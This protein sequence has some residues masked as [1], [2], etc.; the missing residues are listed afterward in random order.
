MR[1]SRCEIDKNEEE[2]YFRNSK[3]R[4]GRTGYCKS[5]NT[6][7]AVIRLRRVKIRMIE[8]KGGKCSRCGIEANEKNLCIFDFH[9]LD[10]TRKD[11][12]FSKIKSKSWDKIQKEIDNCTLLCSNCHRM[13][14]FSI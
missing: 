10:R 6:E 4:K 8:Y 3:G 11:P 13:E 5:C 7:Y 2:F 14:H 1:C 12:N 9:H